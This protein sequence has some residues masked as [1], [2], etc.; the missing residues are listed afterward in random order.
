MTAPSGRSIRIL[1][2]AV[3]LLVLMNGFLFLSLQRMKTRPA[4]FREVD[5]ERINIVEKDGTLKLA[6]FN[7][8]RLTRGTDQREAQ[9][10]IAGMLFYNEDGYECGGLVYMGKK[11]PNGQDAGSGL[12]FDQ[13]RQD[14]SLSLEHNESVDAAGAHYDDGLN[15]VSRPDWTLVKDEY[16]FY[17]MMDGFKGTPEQKDA[18][19]YKNADAGKVAKKRMFIGN[20]RGVQEGLAYDETGLFIRNKYGRDAIRVF[21]DKDNL[22][23]L[24]FFDKLGKNL[25][26]EWKPTK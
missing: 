22:P 21:V 17:K 1:Q 20:R 2:I 3:I 11:T 7:S 8:A 4:R 23:H 12:T 15:I 18:L 13:Y 14:Q 25:I 24:E 16:A 26:Y 10:R 5:A 9:G 6:L 19:L